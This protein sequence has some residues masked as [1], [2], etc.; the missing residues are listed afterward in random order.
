MEYSSTDF[1]TDW[2]TVSEHGQNPNLNPQ[3]AQS[4]IE[5]Y[6]QA[7]YRRGAT[8]RLHLFSMAMA[9]AHHYRKRLAAAGYATLAPSGHIAVL[10]DNVIRALHHL[11]A[12]REIKTNT[13]LKFEEIKTSADSFAARN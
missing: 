2:K 11:I 13:P 8:E 12:K 10:N 5:D 7:R 1:L 9:A 3:S 6:F 4:L